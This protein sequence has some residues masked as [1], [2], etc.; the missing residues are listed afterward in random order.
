M[1]ASGWITDKVALDKVALDKVASD[2]VASGHYL[3][4]VNV[5]ISHHMV[6]SL[7]YIMY[8]KRQVNFWVP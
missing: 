2:K 5:K 6:H 7:N 4:S 3:G 8:Y 1:T